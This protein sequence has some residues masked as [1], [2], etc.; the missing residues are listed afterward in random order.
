MP[1]L[2]LG[3]PT[4][5]SVSI[6]KFNYVPQYEGFFGG[7][8]SL[9]LDQFLSING[10]SNRYFLRQNSILKFPKYNLLNISLEN[11]YPIIRF[12]HL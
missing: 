6:E 10:M 7:V 3:K 1:Y 5:L 11:V 9:T 2:C 12:K 8:V 4:L